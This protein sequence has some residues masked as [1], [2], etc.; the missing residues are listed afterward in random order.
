[1]SR[2]T[3]L[4]CAFAMKNAPTSAGTKSEMN[5]KRQEDKTNQFELELVDRWCGLIPENIMDK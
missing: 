4:A 3:A 5:A 1:M 2:V